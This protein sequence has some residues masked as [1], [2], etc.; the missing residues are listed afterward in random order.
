MGATL[1]E[2]V[3]G[4]APYT[5]ETTIAMLVALATEKP[6][7]STGRAAEA[8]IP[9]S[10][11][12]EAGEPDETGR[13]GG[14]ASADRRLCRTPYGCITVPPAAR[15]RQEVRAAGAGLSARAAQRQ[16]TATAPGARRGLLEAQR[17]GAARGPERTGGASKAAPLAPPP[18]SAPPQ[19]GWSVSR[20]RRRWALAGGASSRRSPCW[21]RRSC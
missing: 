15:Q 16:R 9:G 20:D 21:R 2:A 6:D 17:A 18:V 14:E 11:A 8:V 7:P 4:R 13:S 12:E 10:P 5:R 3:E 1:Y 19:T